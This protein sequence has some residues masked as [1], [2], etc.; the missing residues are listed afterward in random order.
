MVKTTQIIGLLCLCF[1]IQTVM[2]APKAE[3]WARWQAHKPG[4]DQHIDHQPWKRFLG[5][6][7]RPTKGVN[8]IAYGEVT[9]ADKQALNDYLDQLQG[10]SISNY[11]RGEQFAFWVNLYNARTVALILEHYPV[12][13]I[14]D[15]S[16]G[17]FS[18]GPWDEKLMTVE[19]ESLSL[20]D[21]EHRILRPIWKDNRIH[22]AVNCASIGC[23]N[24]ADKPYTAANY[25]RLLTQ[26]ARDYI[27]HP[28]GVLVNG[29]E[30]TVSKIYQWYSVDFGDNERNLLEHLKAYANPDLKRQLDSLPQPDWDYR[31]DWR[32]NEPES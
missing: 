7:V 11:N 15:I 25:E 14:K 6:Y 22:Y 28:R 8:L 24:L 20:N 16:F 30:L 2:A 29:A 18:F 26:G 23:P 17:W 3:L 19:G 31:Y 32:L 27:N 12:D 21:V 9:K 13:S 10:L 1:A 5:K 4:A